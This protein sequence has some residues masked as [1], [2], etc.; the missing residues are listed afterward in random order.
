MGIRNLIKKVKSK[1]TKLKVF[2]VLGFG[3]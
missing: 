3:A 1:P 2:D